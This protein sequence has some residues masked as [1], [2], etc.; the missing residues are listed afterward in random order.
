MNQK[1]ERLAVII[2]TVSLI[3]LVIGMIVVASVGDSLPVLSFHKSPPPKPTV[4]REATPEENER[5]IRELRE[6]N[7]PPRKKTF[8]EYM[9]DEMTRRRYEESRDPRLPPNDGR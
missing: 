6:R 3:L 4:A 7:A 2:I 8:D 9:D 5:A 1:Q